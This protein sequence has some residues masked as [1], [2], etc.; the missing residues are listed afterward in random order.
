MIPSSLPFLFLIFFA[1][2][3]L[4]QD[5][6]RKV[7]ILEIDKSKMVLKFEFETPE[8]VKTKSL[9]IDK[10]AKILIFGKAA[11]LDD[12]KTNQIAKITYN[13]SIEKITKVEGENIEVQNQYKKLFDG[14]TLNGWKG[15]PSVW[16]VK[17]GVL[18]GKNSETKES[19][20]RT[21][22]TFDDFTLRLKFRYHKGN[23]GVNIRSYA[24][25]SF[26][27]AGPQIEIT[28]TKLPKR[29]I[30]HGVIFDS[31][32]NGKLNKEISSP[33]LKQQILLSVQQNPWS[34]MEIT[35][36]NNELTVSIN[37]LIIHEKIPLKE[38]N[39]SGV[40]GFQALGQTHIE[41][42]DI[43]IRELK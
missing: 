10:N 23:S 32:G 35:A 18:I 8:G 26:K 3:T 5:T 43:E 24:M 37:K 39:P 40:I 28:D 16:Q 30:I 13:I 19:F 38:M 31:H 15:D 41:F 20:L 42:K 7:T 2:S 9:D 25:E 12:L 14:K 29:H 22:E 34:E 36:R 21:K 1:S 6:D 17:D 33:Q 27:L 4:A 11:S